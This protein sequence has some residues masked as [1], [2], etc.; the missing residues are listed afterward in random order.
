MRK[1]GRILSGLSIL[2]F[3]MSIQVSAQIDTGSVT[4]TVR[5][6][7]GGAIPGAKVEVVN[8]STNVVTPVVTNSDGTYVV[9]ALI[10]D[11]YDVRVT[12][13]GF[14]PAVE[15]GIRVNVQTRAQADFSLSVGQVQQEIQVSSASQV[16]QTQT[17]D[18]GGVIESRQIN[19]LPLNGRNY[20][21]LALLEPGVYHNPDS[22]V[23]NPAEGRFSANGNLELQNYF[24]LDGID[25][26]TGSENLQEQSTQAV[27]PPPDALQEFR[28]QTRTYSTEFGTSAGAVVN[29]ST[30][31]GTNQFH[32][33]VW[34][35]LRN[36]AL[37][38]NTW[39]NN[40]SGVA[41]GHF[42]QNQFGGTIGGPIIKDRTFFFGA[43]QGLRSSTAQTVTSIVPTAAM[44][45]GDF[46]ALSGTYNLN[47][48]A[49]GQS[50]CI[51]DD[52][53]QPGCIDQVGA[54]LMALYP[55]PN[56]G[57]NFATDFTGNPNYQYVTSV[58]NNT[59]IVTGR[60]DHTFNRHHQIF[61]RYSYDLSDYQSPLWTANPLA[62]NGD[63]ST[64]Y[65]LHDQSLALGWVY[66]PS[67]SLVNSAHFGFLRD[68]SHS[69]PVGLTLGQSAAPQFGL[70][71]IPVNPETAGLPPMYDFGLTTL[72]SSIYRPQFQVAQVWQFADD[73]YKL[74][75]NHSLQFGYEYHENSLNFFD[76]E[77][78]QGVILAEGVYTQTPGFGVADFLL[79]DI[80][81]AIY[82][83]DLEVNN[84]MR[85]NSVYA[86]DTWRVSPTL[87]I[88]YGVRYELY[89]PF[90]LDRKNQLSNFSSANGGEI[91]SATSNGGWYGRTL[92]HPD[93]TNFAPRFGFAWH[94]AA[95]L[96]FRGGFGVFHQ[97]VNRI[98]SEAM[99][100]LN[101][102][103]L[104]DDA[105]SQQLGSTTP[106][107]QLKNGFP[108]EQLASLGID[109][110]QLQIRAQDPNE[111]TSYVE[112]ASF[113]PQLQLSQNTVLNLT[114][115]GNWGRK[116]NRLRNANQGVITGFSGAEPIITFPYTNLNTISQS[117][118]GQGQHAFLELGTNDGNTD[119][120]ALEISLKRQFTHRLAYQISYTWSHNLA[121]YVDNLTGNAFPQ[122]AYDYSQEMSNSPQDVRH[123]FV[124]NAV[125]E[126]PV[127]QG[128]W[129]LN[130]DSMA[131]RL[132]GHW[133]Y[134]V[135][136][137][138]QTGIPFD[139]T[140][141]DE[142]FTGSNHQSY[143]NCVGDPYA[144]TTT[145]PKNYAGSGATGAFL[146]YAAFA[147]PAEGDFGNCRPRMFHGPG[148]QDVDMSLFKSFSLGEAR[149]IEIR[150]EFF[151][152][153]N[154]P[155][156]ANPAASLSSP[157]AAFGKSSATVTDPR[158]IQLAGKFYF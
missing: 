19:D 48:V 37:D 34:D 45:S 7:T 9:L 91:A 65:I 35:Y 50:G 151:N 20:D 22:E 85:G 47:A 82:E 84:Y 111:R 71:G 25:N 102:P 138:F 152:S 30:R 53:I 81:E 88:N 104:R 64:Q 86:Q 28:I 15:H 150:G 11:T 143:P 12:A 61:G 147:V 31:S 127:G 10:P 115:V 79:G 38:A 118:K 123:R 70:T 83:T 49:N 100:E 77:A 141:P 74:I 125:W 76:L 131:A 90:W 24:S 133:Q 26:N 155:S 32:G 21:Q 5:D 73:I 23:A 99:L 158:E 59:E 39:F 75:G 52:V 106:V 129:V 58:P 109:L 18:V 113:G 43:Y 98:G 51:V 134:N 121:N 13:A 124:G 96:V 54:K 108:S 27:V 112:Q 72:G 146:N 154:H 145:D 29:A 33:D 130:H 93:R 57:P 103:F 135:I 68:Y 149:R 153:F 14:S 94:A 56:Y 66:T 62:G 136:A 148:I 101:P 107:F 46:S 137:S 3:L 69:D 6:A 8:T 1:T 36:S 67:S 117:V 60:V 128:G 157:P 95:P 4:G 120:E 139:V 40:N 2:L 41:K 55:D 42:S 126:L 144:G 44:K 92:I 63:F 105:V 87:T 89:P 142:S 156:F 80:T 17:A 78:P 140:A 116:M 119:Y 132:L 122:N 110:P 97:F 114:W 16:L